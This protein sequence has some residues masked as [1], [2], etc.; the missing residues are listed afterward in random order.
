VLA[1][2]EAG[3]RS[4]LQAQQQAGLRLKKFD[5]GREKIA[6][7]SKGQLCNIGDMP[8]QAQ[9]ELSAT[10]ISQQIF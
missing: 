10:V 5:C 1:G 3:Q 4:S 7:E 9:R 2:T 8:D 6:P